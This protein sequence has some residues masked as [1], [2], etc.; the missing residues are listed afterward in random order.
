MK[1]LLA[2]L[3]CLLLTAAVSFGCA[4][5]TAGEDYIGMMEVINCK[6][7]VSM[8]EKA[9]DS[10][11]RL[12]QV[13]LGAVVTDARTHNQKW[14]HATYEGFEGY[15]LAEYLTPCK[16]EEPIPEAAEPEAAAL[17]PGAVGTAVVT[18]REGASLYSDTT[19][20][21]R[22][23]QRLPCGAVCRNCILQSNGV[24]YLE[25]NGRYLYAEGSNLTPYR[26]LS[27][28]EQLPSPLL[29]AANLAY[30]STNAPTPPVTF[31]W[32]DGK[33]EISTADYA[34]DFR[35]WTLTPTED[36]SE[37]YSLFKAKELLMLEKLSPSE[38]LRVAVP[39][40]G[41]GPSV[42]VAY[43]DSGMTTRLFLL[44][45]SGEDGAVSTREI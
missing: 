28:L 10:S 43:V 37:G 29:L 11:P 2:L 4:E 24:M 39:F 44:E 9:S 31:G 45:Q 16:A 14:I 12:I 13:P 25:Y 30:D 26:Q 6:E 36:G 34:A 20:A 1:K 17:Q 38:T 42:A 27:S 15:I 33:L 22:T 7:W 40:S 41:T 18:A 21:T 32:A 3:I 23:G 5:D 19:G 35:L 8:R